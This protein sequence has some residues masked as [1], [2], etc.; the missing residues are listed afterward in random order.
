[1]ASLSTRSHL[2]RAA[3]LA[4]L[5]V[6]LTWLVIT[7][8]LVRFLATVAPEQA[9]RLAPTDPEALLNLAD[10]ELTLQQ[11]AAR[12]QAGSSSAPP[13]QAQK[14]AA[15]ASPDP[16]DRVRAWAE[17]A[18]RALGPDQ[19]FKPAGGPD[20]G[21]APAESPHTVASNNQIRAWAELALRNDPLN[22]RALRILGQVAAAAGDE[23]RTAKFMQAAAR[24]SL[25]EKLPL[26]WLMLKGLEKKDYT[27]A[28]Y[29]A[30]ALLRTTPQALADVVPAL[31]H[32]AERTD[33]GGEV[34]ALLANN[35]PWRADFFSILPNVVSDARTPLDFL[36]AIKDTPAPPTIA[37]LR[38]YL[39]FLVSKKQ[40]EL[41]YYTWLQ[42]LPTEQLGNVGLL[43]NG[44]FELTPTGLPFDWVIAAGAGVTA[45]ILNRP[46]QDGQRALSITFEQGRVE[47][48]SVSQLLMLAPGTYRFVARHKGEIIGRRGLKW[49]IACAGGATGPLGESVMLI[50]LTPV[51]R[52]VDFAFTVPGEDC[53][54]QHLR[55]DLDARMASEQLVTG[56]IWFDEIRIAR[57]TGEPGK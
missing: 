25:H 41:A 31:V 33:A 2:L 38:A 39:N 43:Y 55:L 15:D 26:Y 45:E 6:A 1:L 20:S 28:A 7:S 50:G 8:S 13:T 52:D 42:F 14:D 22:A 24:R 9:L 10:R 47:F 4:A 17:S 56:S 29:Y 3:T 44:S 49:R 32:L 53:R 51:W 37:D 16:N 46:D 18:A 57:V 30:D 40:Y 5:G 11:S 48:H 34:K 12:T 27:A 36:L 54:A 35:P 21:P 19:Q 23:A